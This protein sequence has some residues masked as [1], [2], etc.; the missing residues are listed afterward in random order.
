ML[1]PAATITAL[2]PAVAAMPFSTN[3]LVTS[4]FL[5]IL[6]FFAVLG[7]SLAARSAAKSIVPASSLSSW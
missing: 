6:A 7:T 4:P 5:T 2:A 3:A 1:P